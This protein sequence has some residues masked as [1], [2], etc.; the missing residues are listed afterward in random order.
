MV[1]VAVL[2]TTGTQYQGFSR[3]DCALFD[4]DSVQHRVTWRE[5]LSLEELK[6]RDVRLKF[7][8]RGASLYSFAVSP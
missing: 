7:Y 1:G 5:K 3:Q 8:L 2:D 4:G 6:G